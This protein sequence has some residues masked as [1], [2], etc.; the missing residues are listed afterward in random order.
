MKLIEIKSKMERKKLKLE[1]N[2]DYIKIKIY[3]L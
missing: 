1:I 3:L 2:N